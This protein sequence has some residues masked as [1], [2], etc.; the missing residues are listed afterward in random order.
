MDNQVLAVDQKMNQITNSIQKLSDNL[1]PKRSRIDH[2]SG[3]DVLVQK[4][5]FQAVYVVAAF[6]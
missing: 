3:I 5:F 1:T 2:L 6:Y 4:V